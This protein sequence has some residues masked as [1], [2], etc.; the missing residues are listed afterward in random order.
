MSASLVGSEMCIRDRPLPTR[1]PLTTSFSS[2]VGWGTRAE[3]SQGLGVLFR[4]LHG[5]GGR[6]CAQLRVR[7]IS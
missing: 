5:Q 1:L 7:D 6:V 2:T 4:G 3:P